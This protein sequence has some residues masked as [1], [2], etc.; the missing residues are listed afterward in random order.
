M[1]LPPISPWRFFSSS[2]KLLGNMVGELGVESITG[3]I[4]FPGLFIAASSRGIR[5]FVV[6]NG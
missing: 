6:S 5:S 1:A 3:K 2:L 4:I